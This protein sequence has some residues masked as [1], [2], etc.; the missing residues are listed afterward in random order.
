MNYRNKTNWL[1]KF[2]L[3]SKI[4]ITLGLKYKNWNRNHGKIKNKLMFEYL[5]IKFNWWSLL[6]KKKL[7]G[8]QIVTLKPL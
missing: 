8:L 6:L 3:E 1:L 5:V 7:S 4:K 2:S